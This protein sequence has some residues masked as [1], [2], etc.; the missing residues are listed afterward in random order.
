MF[1]LDASD[2]A[3]VGE[4]HGRFKDLK[5]AIIFGTTLHTIF[6]SVRVSEKVDIVCTYSH[7][8]EIG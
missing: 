2:R 3:R 8:L 5:G 4:F 6:V 7:T 1:G